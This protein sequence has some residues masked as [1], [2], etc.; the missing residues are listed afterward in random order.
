MMRKVRCH[1][2]RLWRIL[3]DQNPRPFGLAQGRL[4]ISKKRRGKDGAASARSERTLRP[5]HTIIAL[6]RMKTRPRAK[7]TLCWESS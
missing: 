2:G 1:R 7:G 6:Q 4:C 5:H 3:E